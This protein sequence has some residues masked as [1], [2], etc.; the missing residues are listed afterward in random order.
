LEVA[1]STG[2]VD[3]PFGRKPVGYIMYSPD[4]YMAVGFMPPDR[5]PFEAADMLGGPRTRRSLLLEPISPIAGDATT[6]R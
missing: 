1:D 5:K 2:A 6:S 4:G 3:Y